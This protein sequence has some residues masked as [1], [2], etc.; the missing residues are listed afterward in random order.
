MVIR[1]LVHPIDDESLLK[2]VFG[3]VERA[4]AEHPDAFVKVEGTP[5]IVDHYGYFDATLS[6]VVL[7]RE[8][9]STYYRLTIRPGRHQVFDALAA[10][11]AERLT[12]H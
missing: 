8:Q 1:I 3:V 10:I 12:A 4:T 2:E 7:A 9:S 5:G 11:I 6:S